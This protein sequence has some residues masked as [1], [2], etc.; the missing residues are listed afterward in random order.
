MYL[1]FGIDTARQLVH[2]LFDPLLAEAPLR[3]AGLDWK[4]S[5]QELTAS[6]GLGVPEYRVDDQG[7]DHR[8]EFTATVIVGGQSHG[9]GDGKTKKEAEQKAAEAAYRVLSER[10]RAEQ[11]A[12]A[13]GN[14]HAQNSATPRTS[15][16]KED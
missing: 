4:T 13:A 15:P 8:K 10:V 16:T 5:L 9:A 3:G 11:E 1:Q 12:A 14:G 6:A 7:P 2:R